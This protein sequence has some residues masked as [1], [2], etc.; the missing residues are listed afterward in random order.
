MYEMQA[1][2][3][4]TDL[5]NVEEGLQELASQLQRGD[6]T[7]IAHKTHKHPQTVSEYLRGTVP[8]I[9]LGRLIIRVGRKLIMS[10]QVA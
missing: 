10:R 9:N 2:I 4:N 8:D 1:E 7:N 5:K 3:K 6:I